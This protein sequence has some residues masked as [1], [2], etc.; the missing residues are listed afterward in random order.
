MR[1]LAIALATALSLAVVSCAA[2]DSPSDA[3]VSQRRHTSQRM[4]DGKEWLTENLSLAT[5]ESYCFD[6]REEHCLR[7]GRLYTW[8]AAQRACQLLEGGWRLPSDDDWRQL[9]TFYGGAFDG[10][11][12]S[13]KAAYQALSSGGRSGFD[14]VLG[15]G[16]AA[17]N[18]GYDDLNAHGFYWT[19]SEID[20]AAAL[21]YNFA[22]G[23]L[24]LYR[25]P[26]GE[27]ALALSVRCVR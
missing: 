22:R 9:A 1:F 5:D 20:S 17:D 12:G 15:G 10:A 23:G 4:M 24:T 19:A 16:R 14:A 3:E 2:N 21:F 18:G 26:D 27:K 6:E 25:Q 7:F 8:E 13:G 11:E